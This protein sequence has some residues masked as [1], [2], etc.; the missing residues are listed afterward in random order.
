M[1]NKFDL[2]FSETGTQDIFIEQL[3]AKY[4]MLYDSVHPIPYIR[5]R[6]YCV[7][8]IFVESGI[9]Y[10]VQSANARHKENWRPLDSYHDL[11]RENTISSDR[12]ILEAEPGY[13]KST[14]A[15]QLVY[16]WCKAVQHSP[17]SMIDILI[18]LQ[19][20]QLGTVSS[21]FEAIRRFILPT[22]STLSET[23]VKT[24]I[25]HST[26]VVII[27]DGY[28][29]YLEQDN[30]N[31]DIYR[32]ISKDMFQKFKVLITTRSSYLPKHLAPQTCRL[33]L[34]GFDDSAREK[35]IRKA[36]VGE[37]DAAA[38]KIIL[39]IQENPVLEDL[40]EVPL[41]FVMFAHITHEN[42]DL[43]TFKSVTV[44]FRYMITCF[45]SHMNNKIEENVKILKS[46][47]T[48][49][50]FLYEIAFKALTGE[51][52]QIVWKRKEL[53]KKLGSY[54]YD[55]YLK[56]G[57]FIEEEALNEFQDFQRQCEGGTNI[58]VRFYHKLF[59]EW[60]TAH[61]LAR[62]IT[63]L[64]VN[65]S[66]LLKNVDPLDLQYLYR[67][68]CGISKEASNKIIK[69]LRTKTEHKKSAILCV[70]EQE[71]ETHELLESITELV[72]ETVTINQKDTRLLQRST[73]QILNV[74]SKQEVCNNILVLTI[75]I[76]H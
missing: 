40:C 55:Y 23:D 20:R 2:Y 33:R 5:D 11:L 32:I 26:S 56:M 19:L 69:Y 66:Q 31:T 52:R 63:K 61:F 27:L 17:L 25:E 28:D 76:W 62:R 14:I 53:R 60:Y 39:D 70:L 58:E 47:D 54:F 71:R 65:H 6:L 10:L 15:L 44:F 74:A 59:C 1:E 72:S 35:Y 49:N 68:S 57:I 67:F 16:D 64:T 37:D 50:T 46:L 73:I 9:E 75:P 29:E 18:F 34:M 12:N 30:T 36:V 22:N 45:H 7:D 3:K 48:K 38:N 21:I 4:E 24:L 42:K 43:H 51:K 41:L 8:K 13:G